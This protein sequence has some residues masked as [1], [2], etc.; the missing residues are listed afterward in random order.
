MGL[1]EK[2]K[3]L[4]DT[5]KGAGVNDLNLQEQNGVLHIHGTAPTADVKNTLWNI[6][7]QLDP[8]YITGDVSLDINLSTA[9]G[10]TEV[11][12]ITQEAVLLIRK[13]PGI[14]QPVVGEATKDEIIFVLGRAND[15]WWLVRGNNNVEGYCYA[16]YLE[17]IG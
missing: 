8:N 2:Y 6:Y 3:L 9:T 11:R 7:N 12:V 17:P 5:A 4:I 10:G 15:Q 13:G 16:Q 1:L 14:E